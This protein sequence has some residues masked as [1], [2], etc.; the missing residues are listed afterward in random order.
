M[1]VIVCVC[2]HPVAVENV[3]LAEKVCCTQCGRVEQREENHDFSSLGIRCDDALEFIRKRRLVSDETVEV[4]VETPSEVSTG[5]MARRKGHELDKGRRFGQ[6]EIL[7]KIGAGGMGVVYEAYDKSL[8]RNVALKILGRELGTRKDFIDR[9]QREARAAARLS[10]PNITHIYSIGEETGFHFF[11]MELV[12]GRTLV[13]LV[14]DRGPLPYLESID[15]ALAV[16]EGLKDASAHNIVHRDIKP[17]NLMR[18]PGGRVKITDFGLAKAFLENSNAT[19][20]GVIMGTPLYMSPEQAQGEVCDLRSDIYSLGG[21]LYYLLHGRP[22]FKRGHAIAVIIAHLTKPLSF[23]PA[24]ARRYPESV[25]KLLER[26]MAKDRAERY[27]N[28]D[29]LISDLKRVRDGKDLEEGPLAQIYSLK[30]PQRRGS[31]T[32]RASKLRVAQ[33]NLK[34]GRNDKAVHLLEE[35]TGQP[36]DVGVRASFLLVKHYLKQGNQPHAV[37][38]LEKIRSSSTDGSDVLFAAWRLFQLSQD[39]V[40]QE[41]LNSLKHLQAMR[42]ATEGSDVPEEAIDGCIAAVEANLQACRETRDSMRLL[43]ARGS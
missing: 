28:Y 3:H 32:M 21:T 43:Y 37:K 22:P 14:K 10:H 25:C 26:M 34:M 15:I 6:Y 1:S 5:G 16:A 27:Q 42:A 30:T 17:A 41:N 9:F 29:Q 33:S 18:L 38:L 7:E 35:L 12:R 24:T 36:G 20:T 2:G 11:A 13:D 8:D 31:D 23:P 4:E 39:R 19:A 40:E